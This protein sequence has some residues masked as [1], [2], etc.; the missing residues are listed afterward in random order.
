[1]F[2]CYKGV[3]GGIGL[4]IESEYPEYFT[5]AE[6][7]IFSEQFTIDDIKRIKQSVLGFAKLCEAS[8]G[9]IL[10]NEC[11]QGL[12][13]TRFKTLYL[14]FGVKYEPIEKLLPNLDNFEVSG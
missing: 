3:G 13:G 5:D 2:H 1:M 14:L 10:Q 11:F 8:P 7:P 9:A 6:L 4:F 12:L